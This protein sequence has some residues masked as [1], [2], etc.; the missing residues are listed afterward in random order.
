MLQEERCSRAAGDPDGQAEDH[1][2]RTGEALETSPDSRH[3]WG[4][5]GEGGRGNG[6][7]QVGVGQSTSPAIDDVAG[8]GRDLARHRQLSASRQ[9]RHKSEPRRIGLVQQ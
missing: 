4:L 8:D 3:T 2:L 9:E 7:L 1:S 5:V 6:V